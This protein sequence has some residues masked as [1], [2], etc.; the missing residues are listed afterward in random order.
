MKTFPLKLILTPILLLTLLFAASTDQIYAQQDNNKTI[1]EFF[2]GLI[3]GGADNGE[4]FLEIPLK[5]KLFKDANS[6][7]EKWEV[8]D[9]FFLRVLKERPNFKGPMRKTYYWGDFTYKKVKWDVVA[10]STDYQ[11]GD[12]LQ[13]RT[14]KTIFNVKIVRYEIHHH[15]PGGGDLLLGVAHPIDRIKIENT[16]FLIAGKKIPINGSFCEKQANDLSDDTLGK[17]R[18]VVAT[19]ANIPTGR[20][21][22][23]IIALQ[24]Q[25]TKRVPQ[26]V[27]YAFFGHAN[28][29]DPKGYW[30]T[31]FIDNDLSVI[32]VIGENG[33]GHIQPQ[34]VCDINGDGI[35][36]VWITIRG[37]E[38]HN[39][40]LIYWSNKAKDGFQYLIN[41]Y[42]GA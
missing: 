30:R 41:A 37:Y 28:E 34:I 4:I 19:D 14:P 35:D 7:K 16:D 20:K 32:K 42:D 12:F 22:E 40:G 29:Y 18:E 9:S 5:S 25:F 21:A 13:V 15:L 1:D 31:M 36:E 27:V 11:V 17:I 2:N 3:V 33:Y 38:G 6:P 8:W 26:Y 10:D 24:G 23:K 39:Y